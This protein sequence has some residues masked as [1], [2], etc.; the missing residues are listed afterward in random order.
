VNKLPFSRGY[1]TIELV[2][3]EM[4]MHKLDG[5]IKYG[6]GMWLDI[7]KS[8]LNLENDMV[9]MKT[10]EGREVF[11]PVPIEVNRFST[12]SI[13]LANTGTVSLIIDGELVGELPPDFKFDEVFLL[14]GGTTSEWSVDYV[15]ITELPNPFFVDTRDTNSM[16]SCTNNENS[17]KCCEL[18]GS[19][20]MLLRTSNTGVYDIGKATPVEFAYVT[21]ILAD[22]NFVHSNTGDNSRVQIRGNLASDSIAIAYLK[23]KVNSGNDIVSGNLRM[24]KTKGKG[25][26]INIATSGCNWEKSQITYNSR[27]SCGALLGQ[28]TVPT[29]LNNVRFSVSLESKLLNRHLRDSNGLVCLCLYG[30]SDDIDFEAIA[31][32]SL[33]SPDL[34]LYYNNVVA[35]QPEEILEVASLYGDGAAEI[36]NKVTVT[37]KH[38]PFQILPNNG[39]IRVKNAVL[40]YELKQHFQ[41]PIVVTDNGSPQLS[42][43]G[44]LDIHINDVNEAPILEDAIV[45]ILENS[46]KDTPVSKRLKAVDVD[47]GQVLSYM[48]VSNP[49]TIFKI[50]SCNGEISLVKPV[51]DYETKSGYYVSVQV[52]D[53]GITG[54]DLLFDIGEITIRVVDVNEDPVI[55]PQSY[56]IEEN[57]NIGSLVG[58]PVAG[59]DP[60]FEGSSSLLYTIVRGNEGNEFNID[61]SSGQLSVQKLLNYEMLAKF[62]DDKESTD[63]CLSIPETVDTVSDI[64]DVLRL[65]QNNDKTRPIGSALQCVP[66]SKETE[67]SGGTTAFSTCPDGYANDG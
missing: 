36:N 59:T 26:M 58:S 31:Y 57:A 6:D 24:H 46:P 18:I 19:S 22:G 45:T 52:T 35:T 8:S 39:E 32:G 51:L 15:Q 66:G 67:K 1:H 23:F 4:S 56:E 14:V 17:Y 13:A 38:S 48:L 25:G 9:G 62:A 47:D 64:S 3:A 28:T 12:Y 33:D 43:T 34:E 49:G 29:N 11:I 41:V 65:S 27:P 54:T 10:A 44:L 2:G 60:D 16:S 42:T 37:S 5:Q 40:N 30:I 63:M 21:S 61:K 20:G 7:T 53:S 50:T 55:E